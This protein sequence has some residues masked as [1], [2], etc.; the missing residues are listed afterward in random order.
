MGCSAPVSCDKTFHYPC[1]KLSGKKNSS[2]CEQ[3]TSI[4]RNNNSET[5][6][7]HMSGIE[8]CV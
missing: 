7:S 4:T 2:S 5:Y 6:W 3:G 1:A 8:I